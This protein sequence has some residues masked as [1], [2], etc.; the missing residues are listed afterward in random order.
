MHIDGFVGCSF[1]SRSEI[2]R[3]SFFK[4]TDDKFN[5]S[6]EMNI[7]QLCIIHRHFP[8][9]IIQDCAIKLIAVLSHK[10]RITLNC[11]SLSDHQREPGNAYN[12]D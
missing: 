10:N 12:L 7:L 6:L 2:D 5:V 1:S 8:W 3:D 11:A 4:P 9:K